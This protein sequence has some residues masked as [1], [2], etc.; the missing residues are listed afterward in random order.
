[1]EKTKLSIQKSLTPADLMNKIGLSG[2]YQTHIFVVFA[3]M[4]YI[5]YIITLQTPFLFIQP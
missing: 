4:W 1:M 3:L 5:V 2:A